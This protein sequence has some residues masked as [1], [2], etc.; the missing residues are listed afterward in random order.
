[1]AGPWED[2]SPAQEPSGPWADYAPVQTSGT[3]RPGDVEARR[4][5]G[6]ANTLAEGPNVARKRQTFTGEITGGIKSLGD[7]FSRAIKDPMSALDPLTEISEFVQGRPLEGAKRL[8]QSPQMEA[9]GGIARAGAPVAT[10]GTSPYIANAATQAGEGVSDYLSS[11]GLTNVADVIAALTSA[12]IDTGLGVGATKGAGLAGQ[13]IAKAL[14][15]T[16]EKISKLRGEQSVAEAALNAEAQ[17]ARQQALAGKQTTEQ[18][19]AAAM[20]SEESLGAA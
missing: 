20:S 19:L 12:G 7:A 18:G 8:L 1:M 2:Y 10:L 6:E 9:V 16:A 13:K 17:A 11:L 14:P 5:Q 3:I 15:N 4:K